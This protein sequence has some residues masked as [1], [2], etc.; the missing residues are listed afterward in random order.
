MVRRRQDGH[1]HLAA[2]GSLNVTAALGR[3][4]VSHRMSFRPRS[5]PLW[6]DSNPFVS[7]VIPPMLPIVAL[8]TDRLLSIL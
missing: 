8:D 2:L 6:W 4:G 1:D 7:C 5:F 3:G